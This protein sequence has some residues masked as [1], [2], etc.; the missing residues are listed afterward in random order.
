MGEKIYVRVLVCVCALWKEK[1]SGEKCI[2]MCVVCKII[3]AE[4]QIIIS[5]N[6]KFVECK[7]KKIKLKK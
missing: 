3:H 4:K 1:K 2:E 7:K 6:F 5:E